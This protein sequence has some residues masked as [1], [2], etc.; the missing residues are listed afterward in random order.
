MVWAM[1]G[2]K[3]MDVTELV[4]SSHH[5]TFSAGAAA[6]CTTTGRYIYNTGVHDDGMWMTG[7]VDCKKEMYAG[8]SGSWI[9]DSKMVAGQF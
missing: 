4:H 1:G 2:H 7:S 5:K 3:W 6:Y 9:T 8:S